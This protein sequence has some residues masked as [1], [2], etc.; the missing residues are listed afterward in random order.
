MTTARSLTNAVAV[1]TGAGSGIGAAVVTLLAQAG[2]TVV[3]IG[4]N[5][6]KLQQVN[7][8]LATPGL[9]IAGD[10]GD[11]NFCNRA[12]TQT[13]DTYGT[14]DL[15]INNAGA[16]HRASA[17]DTTDAAW[18][19]IMR[20]NVDG[21]FYMSRAGVAAMRNKDNKGGAIV[22]TASTCGLVGAAG[23]AA[24]CASK[25]AVVQ[26]TRAMALEC[27]ADKITV[28]AVCPGAIEAPMLFSAHAENTDMAQ[29]RERNIQA[30]P[31]KQI[32]NADEVARAIVYLA[33]EPHITGSMLS[34][35]GG[36]TAG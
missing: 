5:I 19:Q 20:T 30:I 17:A 31:L 18:Q 9:C 10:V 3:L 28:N 22:N 25:G 36:Y 27:A 6:D 29:V 16:M 14:L 23:I 1:V 35:D 12:I 7:D 26:L 8:T 33:S 21:V 2:A 34:I 15:L 11:S 32:A 13:Q 24:Y 4:R